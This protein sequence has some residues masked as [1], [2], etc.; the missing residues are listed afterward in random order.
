MESP[1]LS[2]M[3]CSTS[4][5]VGTGGVSSSSRASCGDISEMPKEEFT[6]E[7]KPLGCSWHSMARSFLAGI[8]SPHP[9]FDPTRPLL[10]L[11]LAVSPF[12]L[13]RVGGS[14]ARAPGCSVLDQLRHGVDSDYVLA[15]QRVSRGFSEN[16]SNVQHNNGKNN[17]V[18]T[19]INSSTTTTSNKSSSRSSSGGASSK[20]SSLSTLVNP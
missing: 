6:R 16:T 15:V 17:N 7:L 9:E 2:S 14:A 3:T 19:T 12:L 1:R 18:T 13:C 11:T 5:G 8:K 4:S 10:P 20:R